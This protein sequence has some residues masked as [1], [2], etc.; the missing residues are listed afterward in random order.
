MRPVRDRRTFVALRSGAI[1]VRRGPLSVAFLERE[2]AVGTQV[3]YALT[4][5]VGGAVERNRLRRRLRAVLAELARGP[6][7]LVPPG[8]LLVSAGPE[9]LDRSPKELRNDVVHV[10]EALAARRAGEV[11]R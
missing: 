8:V 1:R 6:E 3:A 11:A 7:G 2:D 5:R 4:K 9:A 10:L